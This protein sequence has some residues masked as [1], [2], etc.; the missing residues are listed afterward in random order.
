MG[1]TEVLAIAAAVEAAS[2][3]PL[4]AAVVAEAARLGVAVAAVHGF[5]AVP[6]QGARAMLC[7]CGGQRRVGADVS[8]H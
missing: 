3:H 1:G 5:E 4:A 2:E 8:G 7:G 6:G